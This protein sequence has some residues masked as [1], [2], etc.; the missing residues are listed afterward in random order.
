[1]S[2]DPANTVDNAFSTFLTN[3][4]V[5]GISG[6][7]LLMQCFFKQDP[8][9]MA[10]FLLQSVGYSYAGIYH[11]FFTNPSDPAGKT[12]FLFSVGFTVLALP[13]LE[14]T[15]T[16][17]TR[18]RMCLAVPNVAVAFCVVAFEKTVFAALWCLGSFAVISVVYMVRR[19]ILRALGN[20]TIT[21]GFVVLGVFSGVFCQCYRNV[22]FPDRLVFNENGLFHI[23]VAVGL[24]LHMMA[25][26]IDASNGTTTC[27]FGGC[28]QA[29]ANEDG[30][31]AVDES[32]E[33]YPPTASPY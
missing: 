8:Y 11:Q 23:F 30:E 16:E 19:E 26:A 6:C 14:F 27:A 25:E 10:Y 17:N 3:Y 7:A 20:A 33:Q 1:M 24:F 22:V 15:L 2:I 18:L 21:I 9:L 13:C 28:K 4:F 32:P 29:P 5:G 12:I 31:D